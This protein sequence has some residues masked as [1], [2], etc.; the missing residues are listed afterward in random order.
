MQE[1]EREESAAQVFAVSLPWV[2]PKR[3]GGRQPRRFS[4]RN[5]RRVLAI[6]LYE[7]AGWRRKFG[8]AR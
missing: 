5:G 3:N 7:A 8:D 2:S 6:R 1:I 4:G